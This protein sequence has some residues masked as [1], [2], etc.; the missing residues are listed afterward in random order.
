MPSLSAELDSAFVDTVD[1][2]SAT[3]AFLVGLSGKHAGK[4]FKIRP[5]ESLIGRT[6]RA[7]VTLDEKAVSHQHAKLVLTANGCTLTDLGSTNGTFLNDAKLTESKE[8]QAGDVMKFGNSTL[9]YLT[10]AE[11]QDQHT[12]ALARVTQPAIGAGGDARAYG[13]TGTAVSPGTIP[14]GGFPAGAPGLVVAQPGAV[15]GEGAGLVVAD[16]TAAAVLEGPQQ[17][18]LDMALDYLDI[19]IGL[20][21]SYGWILLASM[22]VCGAAGVGSL[23]LA[24]PKAQAHFEIMLRQEQTEN[25]ASHFATRAVDFFTS[26][27][28]NFGTAELIKETLKDLGKPTDMKTVIK[29]G[30]NLT[31]EKADVSSYKGKF[32]HES[33]AFAQEF[34]AKHLHNY[35]Q[36][37]INKSIRVLAKE[38]KLLRTQYEENEALLKEQESGLRD[39][40]GENLDALPES[41]GDQLRSRIG[42]MSRKD[43]LQAEVA[44]LTKEHQ[45]A[46]SQLASEDAFA[47]SNVQRASPF[48]AGLAKIQRDIATARAQGLS[49]G[50]PDIKRLKS[51]QKSLERLKRDALSTS[52]TALDRRTN[53]E[54]KRLK[55]RVAELK[56]A[57]EAS[58]QEL[59]QINER[60][61][62]IEKVAG[63]MPAVEATISDKV[64]QVQ[65]SKELLD[66][67]YQQLKEKELELQFERANVESRYEVIGAPKAIPAAWRRQGVIRGV[68]G[69]VLGIVLGV[70]FSGMLWLRSYAKGRKRLI[71]EPGA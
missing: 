27:E 11:D 8:L 10:D 7:L 54:H 41:A 15:G 30:K 3:T 44:R 18:P 57:L 58:G 19:G 40:K 29:N 28:K 4:L 67:L 71:S 39:F 34:L 23:K 49:D 36:V 24:P 60:L 43:T 26:A 53:P 64:R 42:L 66:K 20:L 46:R 61:K 35:L 31:L 63:N 55:N 9:G 65:A 47:T 32:V 13:V 33:A 14:P 17:N 25:T 56:I 59:G 16:P 62:E 51:E 69:A 2:E 22:V 37:E 48:E 12:R 45:L 70:I 50:H 38:V 6:S 68:G 52:T 1:S 5:G 21:K